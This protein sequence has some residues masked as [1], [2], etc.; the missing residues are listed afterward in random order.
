MNL[1]KVKFKFDQK[2][3][4][5]RQDSH[6]SRTCLWLAHKW[7]CFSLSTP[8]K[9]ISNYLS[10]T[11]LSFW[12][13]FYLFSYCTGFTVFTPRCIFR[14]TLFFF[15]ITHTTLTNR[16][17]VMVTGSGR[18]CKQLRTVTL[19]TTKT[20]GTKLNKDTWMGFRFFCFSFFLLFFLKNK[21]SYSLL[22]SI[23]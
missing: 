1:L 12:I 4:H 19:E 21:P 7:N 22:I 6:Q 11:D 18:S 8:V 5:Q 20:S 17:V 23:H 16:L 14:D 9:T 3:L 15:I 2:W 10:K 13:I